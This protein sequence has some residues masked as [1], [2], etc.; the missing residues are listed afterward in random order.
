MYKGTFYAFGGYAY[1]R[2]LKVLEKYS[3]AD[4]AWSELDLPDCPQERSWISSA[5]YNDCMYIFGGQ[6]GTLSL[7]L[8]V[9]DRRPVATI[10]IGIG[11][12]CCMHYRAGQ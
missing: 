2:R 3:F 12:V 4:K 1:G 11:E 7:P 10:Y 8:I 9:C 5:V 6:C